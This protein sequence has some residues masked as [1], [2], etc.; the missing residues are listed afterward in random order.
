MKN[1]LIKLISI[2]ALIIPQIAIADYQGSPFLKEQVDNRTLPPISERLPKAPQIV[3]VESFNLKTGRYG[4]TI[5]MSMA[6]AKD[7]RQMTV[8]G[9]ARLV[10]YDRN[11]KL[12]ADIVE[13]VDI[14]EGR[15]FTLKLREGHKWSD[16]T[17]F[18]TEDFRYWW[19]DIANNKTLFPVGPPSA[20]KLN[21]EFPTVEILDTLNIRYSWSMPNP[22]FL[23]LLAQA[24]PRYIYAPAHYL[25]QFHEKYQ[26]SEKLAKFVADKSVKNWSALH[27]KNSKAYKNT[28]PDLPSLQPWTLQPTSSKKRFTFNRNAFYHKVDKQG[29][30]LPYVDQWV[31]NITEKKLIPL[32]AATGEVSLQARNLKFKDISLLKQSEEQYGFK[33]NLWRNGKGAHLALYP[34]LNHSNPIW[35]AILRDVRFRRAISTGMNRYAINKILYYGTALDGQNTLLPSSPLY[36]EAYHY[37]WTKHD[38][39]VANALLDDM[40]LTEKDSRGI[41]LMPDG[42]PLE[43]IIETADSGTEQPDVLQLIADDWMEIGIKLYIKPTSHDVLIPRI[44]S[45]ETVMSIFSGWENGMATPEMAP[46]DQAP[47]HQDHYQWPKWGQYYETGG[48]SGE[49]I[50]IP[51]AQ[52]LFELYNEWYASTNKDKKTAIWHEMLKIHSDNLFVIGIVSGTLQ[53]VVVIN[54]LHN[55]PE[56]GIW[57]WDPGAHFGIYSPDLFWFDKGVGGA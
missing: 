33:T 1:T 26:D 17:P 4:G 22:N 19:E 8:Y 44:F 14:Q 34:N 13:S 18:T 37:N 30:Q 52:K 11:Y 56:S 40:G 36:K 12:V 51:E 32:K 24:S 31:F 39:S 41:R 50:D 57:N 9:Y 48:Q 28:N 20:L 42:E 54:G 2:A 23:P 53:P 38:V 27:T 35:R 6:K 47:V 7:T 55:V 16:G 15:I 29:R 10:K 45:G 46:E 5:H 3:D 25:K 21:G 43:I 49:K